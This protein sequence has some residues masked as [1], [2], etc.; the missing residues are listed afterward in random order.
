MVEGFRGSRDK[1]IIFMNGKNITQKSKCW[2]LSAGG[3]W[4]L[5]WIVKGVQTKTGW[6]KG[7]RV[8]VCTGWGTWRK[9]KQGGKRGLNAGRSSHERNVSFILGAWCRGK[10][11]SQHYVSYILW[12]RFLPHKAILTYT[13]ISV[14]HLT[15]SYFCSRSH[16]SRYC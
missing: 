16:L 4:C 2:W 12:K 6:E 7:K 1:A 13:S 15:P 8:K 9:R 5:V 3:W 14:I 10:P 11:P